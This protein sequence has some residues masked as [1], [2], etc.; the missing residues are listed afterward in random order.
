MAD[1]AQPANQ[2][3]LC[4]DSKNGGGKILTYNAMYPAVLCLDSKNG[5]G[6]I[7]SALT[8]SHVRGFAL[9]PK[10]GGAKCDA[11]RGHHAIVALP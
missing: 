10:T 4:L 9:I 5:G 1:L 3:M 6:K 7:S 2:L 8:T 11:N